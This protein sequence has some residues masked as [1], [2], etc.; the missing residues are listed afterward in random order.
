MIPMAPGNI[1]ALTIFKMQFFDT[2]KN[3]FISFG[4]RYLVRSFAAKD[5]GINAGYMI[6]GAPNT[7]VHQPEEH[8]VHIYVFNNRI[9]RPTSPPI[10]RAI[11]E[12]PLE[13]FRSQLNVIS[14]LALPLAYTEDASAAANHSGLVGRISSGARM[15]KNIE[16]ARHHRRPG[17]CPSHR[18]KLAVA[19][20]SRP[21]VED[22]SNSCGEGWSCAYRDTI[23]GSTSARRL[24]ME[25]NPQVLF[26]RLFST[27]ATNEAR[28]HNRVESRGILDAVT[29]PRLYA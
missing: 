1:K 5:A 25:R 10:R 24:P 27:G 12:K 23:S 20:A 9:Y 16:P 18:A 17:R 8:P 6:I 21:V 19:V 22:S 13:P 29:R 28:A 2:C 4:R 7:M 15:H 3:T 11:F 26:E 14:D